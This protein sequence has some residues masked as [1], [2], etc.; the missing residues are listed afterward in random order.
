MHN[1][2]KSKT[3]TWFLI[4][5]SNSTWWEM[6]WSGM[7]PITF[8]FTFP[9]QMIC[10]KRSSDHH[11]SGSS[12]SSSS[13]SSYQSSRSVTSRPFSTDLVQS[14]WSVTTTMQLRK[15]IMI[16]MFTTNMIFCSLSSSG[17]LCQWT[18]NS[19]K[20]PD[21]P[22]TNNTKKESSLLESSSPLLPFSSWS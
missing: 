14:Q 6:T 2:M 10:S 5:S 22:R 18:S 19:S 20:E 13:L 3:Q 16:P 9:T 1:M 17:T 4:I 15:S 8:M 12:S 7:H 11:G 21:C